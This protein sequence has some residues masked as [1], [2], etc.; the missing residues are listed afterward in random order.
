[1]LTIPMR[2]QSKTPFFTR[3]PPTTPENGNAHTLNANQLSSFCS[4]LVFST[5]DICVHINACPQG[6]YPA[7]LNRIHTPLLMKHSVVCFSP[8]RD[9]PGHKNTEHF[10]L[11]FG[12][13]FKPLINAGNAPLPLRPEKTSQPVSVPNSYSYF[14]CCYFIERGPMTKCHKHKMLQQAY[15]TMCSIVTF[16]VLLG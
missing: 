13:L 5:M 14:Y 15:I 2:P 4:L 16:H 6:Y 9:G 12:K 10:L 11:R 1:M 7:S 3:T 8:W